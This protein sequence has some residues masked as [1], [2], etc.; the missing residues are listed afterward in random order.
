MPQGRRQGCR[1]QWVGWIL[2]P[3]RAEASGG[4]L[5]WNEAMNTSWSIGR[6]PTDQTYGYTTILN[7]AGE[8]VA[9]F[10]RRDEAEWMLKVLEERERQLGGL[11]PRESGC[12][13]IGED[14]VVRVG[15]DQG[16]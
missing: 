10:R 14:E 5:S 15:Q 6:G 9:A 4:G 16:P 8:E 1:R 11:F 13:I 12:G 2:S 7:A 3:R